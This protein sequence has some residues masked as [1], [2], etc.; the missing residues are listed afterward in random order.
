MM[1]ST[2]K[3]IVMISLPEGTTGTLTFPSGEFDYLAPIYLPTGVTL[4]SSGK[5][6]F[7]ATYAAIENVITRIEGGGIEISAESR[8]TN[9]TETVDVS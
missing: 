7:S 9:P 6:T 3:Q 4:K 5:T 8:P 2:I 1:M